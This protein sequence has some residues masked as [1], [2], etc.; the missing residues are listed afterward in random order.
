[1]QVFQT[2]PSA[3][4]WVPAL[5]TACVRMVTGGNRESVSLGRML[6]AESEENQVPEGHVRLDSGVNNRKNRSCY[7]VSIYYVAGTM[8]STLEYSILLNLRQN[9]I[10]CIL[11]MMA[12]TVKEV[13]S[14]QQATQ[15]VNGRWV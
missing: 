8:L 13:T 14:L 4:A 5:L 15:R 3:K 6:A 7:L 10:N 9:T 11:Q 2:A 1:M 12:M